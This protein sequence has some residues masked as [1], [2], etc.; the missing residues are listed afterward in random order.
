MILTSGWISI[1]G[2]FITGI[3]GPILVRLVIHYFEKRKDPL[4]EAFTLGEKVE[5]KLDQL[6]EKHDCDRIY[7]LQFHN[8]GHY[9]PTGKSIQKF[10]M[11]YE[12]VKES[13]YS[14]RHTFQNIPVHLFSKCL[15]QLATEDHI[16]IYDYSDQ[17]T[18]TYGLKS[19]ADECDIVSSYIFAVKNIDGKLVGVIGLDFSNK[20]E[21]AQDVIHE[22]ELE[23]TAIGGELIKYI[24]K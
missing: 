18:A 21:L 7:I 13:K 23:A 11:F 6:R 20:T 2:A 14:I 9:Y 19:M 4:K 8:G 15:K 22:L 3:L 12:L 16:S 1:L 17:T 5:E 10:S 24:K